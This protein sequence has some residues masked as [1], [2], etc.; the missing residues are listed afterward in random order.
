[1][2]VPLDETSNKADA[3]LDS[4]PEGTMK[5]AAIAALLAPHWE[6]PNRVARALH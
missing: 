1:M 6:Q 5:M 4:N 3:A 2:A